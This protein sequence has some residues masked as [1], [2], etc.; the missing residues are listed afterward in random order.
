MYTRTGSCV[1]KD[2]QPE[3]GSTTELF[4]GDETELFCEVTS[5]TNQ[6]RV[7]LWSLML[8]GQTEVI[9]IQLDDPLYNITGPPL[10]DGSGGLFNTNLTIISATLDMDNAVIYCGSGPGVELLVGNFTLR[11]YGKYSVRSSTRQSIQFHLTC[12]YVQLHL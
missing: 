12:Y 7:T 4:V 9:P 3:I 5:P 11:V 2:S 1:I 10:P 6:P 8:D